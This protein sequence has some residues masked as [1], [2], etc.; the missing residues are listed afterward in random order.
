MN[1]PPSVDRF[2]GL[3]RQPRRPTLL[4]QFVQSPTTKPGCAFRAGRKS[5]STP[6]CTCAVPA[7]NQHP[8]RAQ[9]VEALPPPACRGCPGRTRGHG[10]LAPPAWR[11]EGDPAPKLRAW[12]VRRGHPWLAIRAGTA[13]RRR[14]RQIS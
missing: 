6:T 5:V 2:S 9:R 14:T 13:S 1:A 10:L 4:Q 7:E 11:L 8:P 12:T 3:D